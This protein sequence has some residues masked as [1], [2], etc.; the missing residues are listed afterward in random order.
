M[1]TTTSTTTSLSTPG[2][3]RLR[4]HAARLIT[5]TSFTGRQLAAAAA[6]LLSFPL[7][8]NLTSLAASDAGPTPRQPLWQRGEPPAE[9]EPLQTTAQRGR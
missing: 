7:A 4:P 3:P 1:S 9:L 6:L 2:R 8:V 5:R